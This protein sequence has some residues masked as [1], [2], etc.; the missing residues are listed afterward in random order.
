MD[1]TRHLTKTFINTNKGGSLPHPGRTHTPGVQE[2]EEDRG[3][4]RRRDSMGDGEGGLEGNEEEEE[5]AQLRMS[6][7]LEGRRPVSVCVYHQR[8]RAW[9][10]V[11]RRIEARV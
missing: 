3:G 2:E 8:G 4:K 10:G 6:A 11:M 9:E 1:G 7:E 5:A